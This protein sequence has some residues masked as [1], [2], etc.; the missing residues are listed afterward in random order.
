M[1][2]T[3]IAGAAS[4]LFLAATL[5]LGGCGGDP[6]SISSPSSPSSPSPSSQPSSDS[7]VSSTAA[8]SS[9]TTSADPTSR[10]DVEPFVIPDPVTGT[11]N[12]KTITMQYA[13]VTDYI[14]TT[15]NLK[16][17][18]FFNGYAPFYYYEFDGTSCNLI[19][20]TYLDKTGKMICDPIYN[21]VYP[22]NTDGI[23]VAE[24]VD[25]SKVYINTAGTEKPAGNID[26][27]VWNKISLLPEI[28]PVVM[29]KDCSNAWIY[30]DEAVVA[31][32]GLGPYG[33]Y[34]Q[35][36][37]RNGILLI[38]IK[39]DRIGNFYNGI[40]PII[41]NSR[42]GLID[43]KGNIVIEP[44][45]EIS[46]IFSSALIF[47]EDRILVNTDGYVGIIEILRS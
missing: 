13:A 20:G 10:P 19:G 21:F 23:A 14:W 12:G 6:A 35:L 25:G 34:Y 5:A 45:Y 39:F 44:C 1:K 37:D 33:D 22:F 7:F 8:P 2:R 38:D 28:R 24:K 32:F 47:N 26:V 46:S 4:A 9:A 42:L 18:A 3:P 41:K 30:E 36:F 31:S 40:A 17:E 11:Y 43:T 27:G 29:P 16:P 15:D